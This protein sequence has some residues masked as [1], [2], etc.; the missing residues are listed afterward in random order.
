[1]D[2]SGRGAQV[3]HAVRRIWRDLAVP[4][5]CHRHVKIVCQINP[6]ALAANWSG[7]VRRWKRRSAC[8]HKAAP[9]Q[10]VHDRLLGT[11]DPVCEVQCSARAE[12]RMQSE[13]TTLGGPFGQF[14]A[15]TDCDGFNGQIIR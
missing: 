4:V 1:M 2:R 10:D 8:G 15:A 12:A 7:Q 9:D 14:G 6:E 3:R 5:D 13:E 11:A